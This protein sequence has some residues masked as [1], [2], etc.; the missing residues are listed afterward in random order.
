MTRKTI[1]LVAALILAGTVTAMAA[2]Q[3][4]QR[5]L[6]EKLIRL[7][8]VANSDSPA[9]QALKLRVRD[10]VLAVTEPVLR[11]A[12]DPEA[13]VLR[14]LPDIQSAAEDCMNG[15]YPVTVSYGWELFPTRV[16][17]SFSLPAGV[18]RSVRVT[19]GA[20]EGKNWWCVVFPSICFRAAAADLEAAAQAGGFTEEEVR[21]ITEDGADYQLKFKLMEWL[22]KTKAWLLYD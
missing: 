11:Q 13:A 9:D 5:N 4:Q 8:V 1:L 21:L 17:E 6:S 16:Y 10:A 22:Q 14:I 19:V 2:L 7:H 20:G 15:A 3:T 12:E 18:Y